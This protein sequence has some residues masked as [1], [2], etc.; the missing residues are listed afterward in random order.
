MFHKPEKI[1][2]THAR[3]LKY[4]WE[5]LLASVRIETV[6]FLLAAGNRQDLLMKQFN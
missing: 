3:T 6:V 2:N 1:Q 4:A 5:K